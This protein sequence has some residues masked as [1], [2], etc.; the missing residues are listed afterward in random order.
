MIPLIAGAV[1]LF[2]LMLLGRGYAG[3]NAK[4][5][6]VV[7]KPVGGIALAALAALLAVRGRLD[8]ALLAAAASALLFGTTPPWRRWTGGHEQSREPAARSSSRMSRSEALKVLDLKEGASEDD[9]R[10]AHRRLIM[11]THPDRGG[12]SYL[13]AKINEAKDVLLGK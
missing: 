9:I 7:L 4:R 6:A 12:S 11:Q 5:L 3:A 8:F 10:A 13:A 2:L 1:V